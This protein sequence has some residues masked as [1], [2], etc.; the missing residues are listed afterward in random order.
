MNRTHQRVDQQQQREINNQELRDIAEEYEERVKNVSQI[1]H[2]KNPVLQK[3]ALPT[4]SDPKLWL[5]RLRK[6][7]LEKVTAIALLNKAVQLAQTSTNRMSI[8]SAA[9]LDTLPGYIYV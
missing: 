3:S 9:A 6:P 8:L 1:E 2:Q 4:I 5:V 7:G